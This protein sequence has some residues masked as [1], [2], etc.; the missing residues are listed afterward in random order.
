MLD[1]ARIEAELFNLTE[2]ERFAMR[3]LG[4]GFFKRLEPLVDEIRD[5]NVFNEDVFRRIIELA[6]DAGICGFNIPSEYGG[7]DLPPRLQAL[8]VLEMCAV[9]GGIGLSIGASSSLAANPIMQFGTK[10]QK[11][12]WLPRIAAGELIGCYCQTEA[13]VGSDVAS[14]Q[15]RAVQNE[16]GRWIINGSK[17][18]ITN[19]AQSNF[20][21]VVARTNDYPDSPHKGITVFIVDLDRAKKEGQFQILNAAE[22]KAG[23]HI[24]PTSAIAFV[25]CEA[26]EVLGEVDGGWAIVMT[27]LASS[28]TTAI[29]PQGVGIAKAAWRIGDAYARGRMQ[30]GEP[31]INVP[32]VQWEVLSAEAGIAQAQLLLLRSVLLRAELGTAD[33]RPWQMEASE[34]KLYASE[35]AEWAPSRMMQAMGGFG[36]IMKSRMPK[37]WHDGRVVSIYEGTSGIQR[38][39]IGREAIKRASATLHD[40]HDIEEWKR[41][42]NWVFSNADEE[43]AFSERMNLASSADRDLFREFSYL[44][45]QFV[46]NFQK[47]LEDEALLSAT[48]SLPLAWRFL[49][50]ALVELE[51][52]KLLIW[53]TAYHAQMGHERVERFR[54][55]ARWALQRAQRAVGARG[56]RLDLSADLENACALV[57]REP[58]LEEDF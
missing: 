58:F 28:R 54:A 47:A 5:E 1:T 20:A 22:R 19:G 36:Y 4:D 44:R 13:D 49:T 33:S 23:L 24:S 10:E 12:R 17:V 31:I 42:R 51:G 52:A 29:G 37:I 25:D 3:E 27:T 21:L 15:T 57:A 11:R 2:I 55:H 7:I 34:T 38:L 30:F 40:E 39:I 8:F 48:S 18:F 9:D 32:D 53:K 50:E 16:D 26:D 43:S 41:M 46:E 56:N 35:L 14:I 45:L 6:R